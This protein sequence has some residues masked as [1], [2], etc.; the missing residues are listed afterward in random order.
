MAVEDRG[1]QLVVIAS[2][3]IGLCFLTVCLRCYVRFF[4]LSLFRVED[5]L[6]VWTLVHRN[7][8]LPPALADPALIRT[9]QVWSIAYTA[10]IL[11]GIRYGG[12]KHTKAVPVEN[13]PMVLQ[14]RWAGELT[15]VVASMSLKLTIG[16]FLLRICSRAWHRFTIWTVLVVCLVFNLF[17]LLV[18]AFQCQPVQ[19]FWEQ[20]TNKD[21]V[22]H[23]VSKKVSLN[24]TYA[25]VGINAVADWVLGLL[26]FAL[27]RN[28]DLGKRQRVSVACIL[29]LG[30]LASAATIVRIFYVWQ[31]TNDTD[32]VYDF[33]DLAIWSTVE[34]AIG[35][36][37]SSIATL[38]PLVKSFLD[39]ATTAQHRF[40]SPWPA[41]GRASRNFKS[42]IRGRGLGHEGDNKYY[43]MGPSP[44]SGT[45]STESLKRK[46][47]GGSDDGSVSAITGPN[48]YDW[49]NF[50]A[51][52]SHKDVLA[53]YYLPVSPRQLRL[54]LHGD[55]RQYYKPEGYWYRYHQSQVRVNRHGEVEQ[56]PGP[57]PPDRQSV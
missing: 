57:C 37:A 41:L 6:A 20:Y 16:I 53:G 25:A 47:D 31:L 39:V 44:P 7:F 49:K 29:A 24:S 21:M 26:P 35:L 34:N 1:P 2:V 19:Y 38:R 50:D 3:C 45:A 9:I 23:C 40:S 14:M 55:G 51:Y 13:M 11:L 15:Y 33:T 12:G 4:I 8:H 43:Q 32:P 30:S 22:G 48:K 18:A 27:V 54:G 10:C 28:L 17:Y 5:W 52:E 42:H 56:G 36:T 46:A